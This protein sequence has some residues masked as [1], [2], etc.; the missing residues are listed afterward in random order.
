MSKQTGLGDNYYVA[1]YDLSGDV[2]SLGR[3]GGGP[4]FLPYTPISKS[5]YVRLGGQRSAEHQFVT[6]FDPNAGVAGPAPLPSRVTTDTVATYCRGTTL[7]APAACINAKQVNFDSTRAN[8]GLL[9]VAV[10]M[11]S[12]GYGMEWGEQLT[13][14]LRTDTVATAGTTVDDGAGTTFGAQAYLQVTAFSGTSVDIIIEHSTNN[15]TWATLMDFGAQS[16]IGASRISVANTTTVNRYVRASTGTGT[17]S[18]VTFNVVFV[19]NLIAGVV[20]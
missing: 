13:P 16:A 4:Q 11:Q 14:G 7:G 9:T 6:F 15:S 2:N 3:V 17:F 8:T 5:A 10:N 12:N 1:G 20:F 18:S 19:R